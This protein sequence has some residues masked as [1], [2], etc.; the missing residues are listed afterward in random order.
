MEVRLAQAVA[1][2]C[3]LCR[4]YPGRVAETEVGYRPRSPRAHRECLGR[5]AETKAG[6]GQGS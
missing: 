4:G 5:V 3:A 6:M 1:S 2:Q